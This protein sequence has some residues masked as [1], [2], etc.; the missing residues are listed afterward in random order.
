MLLHELAPGAEPL[1]DVKCNSSSR[2]LPLNGTR[3]LLAAE[4]GNKIQMFHENRSIEVRQ[5]NKGVK[6]SNLPGGIS[7]M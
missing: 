7:E 5:K 1:A 3:T 6:S 2:A 4:T